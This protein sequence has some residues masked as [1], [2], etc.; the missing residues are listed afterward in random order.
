MELEDRT[1]VSGGWGLD[2]GEAAKA[3]GG[4]D[5]CRA[6]V[7]ACSPSPTPIFFSPGVV[8]KDFGV[9]R[10]AVHLRGLWDRPGQYEDNSG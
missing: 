2:G 3:V 7:V 8:P 4:K 6:R 5:D 1:D 9:V 10:A